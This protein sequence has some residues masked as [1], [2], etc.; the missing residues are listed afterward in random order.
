MPEIFCTTVIPT[1]ARPTLGRAVESVLRQELPAAAFEVI[2]VND[3]GSPL[4]VAAWQRDPRVRVVQTPRRER[5]VARNT[6][7]AL[8]RGRYLHFLDDDD[9][10][11]PDVLPAFWDHAQAYPTAGWLY[12]MT[13]LVDR[14]D[15]PLLQLEHGL[16]GN[17]FT[18]VMAGEWIPLAS[19]LVQSDLFFRIGGFVPWLHA[20]QD[21]DLCRRV[22]LRS[23][24][25]PVPITVACVEMGHVGSSTDYTHRPQLSRRA[26]EAIL[27]DTG[28]FSRLR[29]SASSASW[30]G[31]VVRFYLTSVG[32]NLQRGRV[33][34][35][36]SRAIHAM[37]AV[38][39][40]G[41]DLG[42]PRFWHAVLYAYQSP[43]FEQRH[44][45]VA[46]PPGSSL[47]P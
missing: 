46:A 26:R 45:G 3:S 20:G 11:L 27:S 12:G 5:C 47:W 37:A 10:L 17:C 25:V 23:S 24:L 35:A 43:S 8:A 22:A 41:Q 2:V 42:S 4:P 33:F 44:G 32:W 21:I 39:V 16:A 30:R 36:A 34:T 38:A 40:A 14:Q 9:W 7:A 1:I 28:V 6:G 19:S 18:Q 31:R 15:R 13:R 29:A